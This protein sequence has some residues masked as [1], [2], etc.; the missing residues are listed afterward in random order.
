MTTAMNKRVLSCK[1]LSPRQLV[2]LIPMQ[3]L[4]EPRNFI[5][6]DTAFSSD[7][8]LSGKHWLFH[9]DLCYKMSTPEGESVSEKN[10][11]DW[12]RR[13]FSIQ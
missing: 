12:V 10:A 6:L 13:N 3:M 8:D 4:F 1:L 9:H 11:K 7:T 2:K 5:H